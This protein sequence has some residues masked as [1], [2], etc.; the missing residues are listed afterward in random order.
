[1]L[2]AVSGDAFMDDLHSTA[3][4]ASV[5]A[6]TILRSL[7]SRTSLMDVI[8]SMPVF[9]SRKL[10]LKRS[11]TRETIADDESIVHEDDDLLVALS[12]SYNALGDAQRALEQWEMAERAYEGGVRALRVLSDRHPDAYVK[13]LCLQL[14]NLAMTQVMN[15]KLVD[16]AVSRHE[17]LS[18]RREVCVDSLASR[19]RELTNRALGPMPPPGVG[20]KSYFEDCLKF[21]KTLYRDAR[22]VHFVDQECIRIR[23]MLHQ[24]NDMVHREHLARTL[25]AH[26]KSLRHIFVAHVSS[27]SSASAR[28]RAGSD[29]DSDASY[30]TVMEP[31]EPL[32]EIE[33]LVRSLNQQGWNLAALG[34]YHQATDAFGESVRISH[35]LQTRDPSGV[36]AQNLPYSLCA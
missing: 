30:H 35:A 24:D 36:G 15:N 14:S 23:R 22:G 18:L 7:L 6:I 34:R 29:S 32:L 25:L 16:A 17:S 28:A 13:Q 19:G 27:S 31:E 5:E 3:R 8:K 10:H 9:G 33:D 20:S 4:S 11:K 12:E 1:M 21:C 26:A 2:A